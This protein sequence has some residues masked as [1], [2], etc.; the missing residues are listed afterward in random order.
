MK[1]TTGFV[2]SLIGG[3]FNIL[4]G[5]IGIL[6]AILLIMV[7]S[8]FNIGSGPAEMADLSTTIVLIFIGLSLWFILFGIMTIIFSIKI[9][10]SQEVKKGAIGCAI[11]GI[12][13]LNI[14]IIIGAIFAFKSISIPDH[15]IQN[16]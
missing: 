5:F 4:L 11:F 8:G 10:N 12:I 9:N 16:I 6:V 15:P 13:T 14:L 3:I 7:I 2:L 1:S